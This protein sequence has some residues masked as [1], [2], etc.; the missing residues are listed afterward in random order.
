MPNEKITSLWKFIQSLTAIL[1]MGLAVWLFNTVN[2]LEDRVASIES[3]KKENSAQWKTLFEN[4][5]RLQE[6]EIEITV[7]NRI[8][9]ILLDQKKI[10]VHGITLQDVEPPEE[11]KAERVEEFK[12]QQMQM[13]P[14][15]K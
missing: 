10:D 4:S 8:F 11:E 3:N 13:P 6:L 7:T 14:G 9:K 2:K 12:I 15:A 5:R 1:I